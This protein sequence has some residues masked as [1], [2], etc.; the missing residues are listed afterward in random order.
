MT[1]QLSLRDDE[2]LQI[3]SSWSTVTSVYQKKKFI[4]TLYSN[5]LASNPSLKPTFDNINVL[6]QHQV[7]F[8]D[9]LNFVVSHLGQGQQ[10][11][12]EFLFQFVCENQQFTNESVSYLEP[13]GSAFIQTFKECM[14]RQYDSQLESAWIRVYI[15]VANSLLLNAEDTE[16]DVG[17]TFSDAKSESVSEDEVHIAP[18]NIKKQEEDDVPPR[19]IPV[20]IPQPQQPA[21]EQT[22]E[23]AQPKQTELDK[24]NTIQF[25]L[26]SNEK[27]RGFRRNNENL[28]PQKEPISVK[29]PSSNTFQKVHTPASSNMSASL[30]SLLAKSS[31]SSSSASSLASPSAPFDPRKSKRFGRSPVSS[32]ASSINEDCEVPLK[33][34]LRELITADSIQDALQ[35][36]PVDQETEEEVEMEEPVVPVKAADEPPSLLRKLQ[37]RQQPRVVEYSSD[38]EEEQ[39]QQE[40]PKF[41]PRRRHRRNKSIISSPE[42][43]EIDE[44]EETTI[45]KK[46]QNSVFTE[47]FEEKELPSVPVPRQYTY[48]PASFGI[49]GLAPIVE[50]NDFDEKSSKYE[51]DIEDNASSNYGG[52]ESV[53]R[54][55]TDEASSG[56]STLSLHNSDYRSSISSGTEGSPS[57]VMNK[58]QMEGTTRTISQS[59]E[60]SYMKPLS[61]QISQT[62]LRASFTNTHSSSASSLLLSP[63]NSQSASRVSLGFM[64]S[65]FVL[66]KEMETLGFNEPE[67]VLVKPPTIPAAMS[68]VQSLPSQRQSYSTT[69]LTTQSSDEDCFDMLNAFGEGSKTPPQLQHRASSKK[70]NRH[71]SVSKEP[72]C[73]NAEIAALKYK[74]MV[75]D[76][77]RE[78]RSFRKRLSSMF[79]SKGSSGNASSSRSSTYGQRSTMNNS[80][81]DLASINTVETKGSSFSGFSFLSSSR[82]RQSMDTRT[83]MSSTRKGNKYVVKSSAYDVFA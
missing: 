63:K 26:N 71:G 43:S 69:T 47:G 72:N 35:Q 76:P 15:F 54:S 59:S 25:S 50:A 81:S 79:G 78:R 41:D 56:A 48:E 11:L 74:S 62:K 2:L 17:S 42:S 21:Q 51:S 68:S 16:S 28:A 5:L 18:L 1:D 20:T 4:P 22:P 10:I 77:P 53:D 23:P 67:N 80:V 52:D 37:M 33:S 82:R 27:Y 49:R 57:P 29:I 39:E 61:E 44:Q 34:P 40:Q 65:S 13:M 31:P 55:S 64:R 3:K 8:E 58:F 60:V 83:T 9:I 24:A 66:K 6:E 19:A 75:I 70:L 38:E 46:A 7:I 14:N 45:M 12:D 36:D 32:S 73:S 30:S